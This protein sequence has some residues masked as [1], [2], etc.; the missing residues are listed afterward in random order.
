MSEGA[1]PQVLVGSALSPVQHNCLC[2]STLV[3]RT[4][5]AWRTCAH[6]S[7]PVRELR[8]ERGLRTPGLDVIGR[9][10]IAL[11][12]SL[13]RAI[14]SANSSIRPRVR[15]TRPEVDDCGTPRSPGVQELSRSETNRDRHAFDYRSV[16]SRD[17][18]T[19]MASGR[20]RRA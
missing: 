3:L 9:L 2:P 16:K 11:G 5:W 15:T 4:I 13:F 19:F 17:R 14:P 8:S 20:R 10:A 7:R 1:D 18:E 6:R 12:V